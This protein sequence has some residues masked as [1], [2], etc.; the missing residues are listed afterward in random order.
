MSKYV[1]AVA[2]AIAGVGL[3]VIN[4][5]NNALAINGG[6]FVVNDLTALVAGLAIVSA[7][8]SLAL[9]EI[10]RQSKVTAALAV[11]LICG[12]AFAS[13]GYT[14]SRVGLVADNGVSDALGHNGEIERIE[15]EITSLVGKRDLEESKGGC[16]PSCRAIERRLEG[17]R[18]AL[19]GLGSRKVVDPAGERL[20]AVTGGWLTADRYRTLHPVVVAGT[21]ELGVSLLLTVAGL[22][23]DS[24][25]KAPVAMDITPGH[26]GPSKPI[27][28]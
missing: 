10:S 3:G 17:Q 13:V 24:S 28:L 12:C 7:M 19:A 16:G 25:R 8:L 4:A 15:R 11:L 27:S 14:L 21:L 18:A 23:A 5:W 26:A 20:E 6:Q 1:A 9:G 2:F 22:F